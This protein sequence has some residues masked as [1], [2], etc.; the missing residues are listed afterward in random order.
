[1]LRKILLL[2]SAMI[3]IQG[4]DVFAQEAAAQE[5]SAPEAQAGTATTG[6]AEA[7]SSEE[8]MNTV[9]REK[10]LDH[11]VRV[12]SKLD[13]AQASHFFVMYSNYS[14][15]SLTNN[16]EKDVAEA[17]QKCGDENPELKSKVDSRFDG[18]K[19]TVSK[20][21][22]E[23]QTNIDNMVAA[24]DYVPKDDLD[25]IFALVDKTRI[26]ADSR[27]QRI[28]VSTPEACEFMLTKMD[29]T[30]KTMDQ[31]LRSTVAS[32]PNLLKKNQQ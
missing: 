16:V 27:F 9:E 30:E 21:R 3:L 1:M 12:A 10:L 20:A 2:T 18:W 26:E 7:V 11:V 6:A 31:L 22:E 8:K 32:Y 15:I 14:I 24:Q 17:V 13:K 23:A 25:Q 5:K 29:E 28:P 4:G 19:T